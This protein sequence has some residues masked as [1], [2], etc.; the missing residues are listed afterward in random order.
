M[1][2]T[3]PPPTAEMR[4]SAADDTATVPEP[5]QAGPPSASTGFYNWLCSNDHATVGRTWL[6]S[7][8]LAGAAAAVVGVL[9]GVE[10][11]DP[12]A[13]DV[14]GGVNSYFQMW[15]LY[16]FA[17]VL[18]VA[19]PLFVG[20]AAVVVPMQIGAAGMAFPRAFAAAVWL[21]ML[22][23]GIVIVSVLAGGGWGALDGVSVAEADAIGLTLVGTAMVIGSLLVAAACIATTVISLRVRGMSLARVPLFS[24]SM[25]V[26]ASVWLLTLPV[27]LANIALIYVDLRGSSLSF[28]FPQGPD[29]VIYAQLEW[30]FL[31]PQ[32]YAVAI[33]VLGV[34]GSVVPVAAGVR[35]ASHSAM[36]VMIGLFGLL[37]VGGWSQPY[38]ADTTEDFLF[39]A[40]GLAILLPVFGSLGGAAATL[41]AGRVPAAL[42]PVHLIGA[43]GGGLLLLAAVVAGA[44]RVIEPFGLAG[45]AA[46]TGTLNLVVF[47]AVSAAV[48]GIW[49][50]GPQIACNVL[51]SGRGRL[52]AASLVLGTLLLGAADVA[53]GLL[54][55][56]DVMEDSSHGW[57]VD[58]MLI[59]SVIGAAIL[60]PALLGVLA[61]IASAARS[62]ST[63]P[64]D[65]W[66]GHSLEWRAGCAATAD[67]GTAVDTLTAAG[68]MLAPFLP[69]ASEAPLLDLASAAGDGPGALSAQSDSA[70]LAAGTDSAG[71]G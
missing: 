2:M 36:L 31:Q 17:V 53:A 63:C 71:G 5:P 45:S 70:G 61:G 54:D 49:F 39:V 10:R 66:G 46:H 43:L 47:A 60:V 14:F 57:S 58:A 24:W 55:A 27:A 68:D 3:E 6:A 67:A 29:P 64:L 15:T 38:F 65:P 41:R 25:L 69:V 23:A 9:L 8:L 50:W 11:A 21:H 13:I 52:V 26:T 62:S 22:G 18:F 40:F 35:H 16:R 30:L 59:V 48:G 19:A 20:L 51:P 44:L 28:G 32:V 7:S 33:P 4:A 56:P 1:T 37:A 34:L 12:A 42:P